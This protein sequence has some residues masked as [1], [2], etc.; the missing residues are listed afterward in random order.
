M[1]RE[2]GPSN[3]IHNAK[4]VLSAFINKEEDKFR[5][6]RH[7]RTKKLI[8]NEKSNEKKRRR[9]MTEVQQH[10]FPSDGIILKSAYG[11][12]GRD[13]QSVASQWLG[14][15]D[16]KII[17]GPYCNIG[18]RAVLLDQFGKIYLQGE[19]LSGEIFWIEG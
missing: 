16:M 2:L 8:Q 1:L 12:K 3:S 9:K 18:D 19:T 14:G 11:R 17:N 13:T 4:L 10:V 15:L 6:I 5:W 7:D